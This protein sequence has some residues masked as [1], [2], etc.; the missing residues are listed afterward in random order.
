MIGMA[1]RDQDAVERRR[2]L[3]RR[4]AFRIRLEPRI[5]QQ[6]LPARRTEMEAAVAQPGDC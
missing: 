2:L 1:V 3:P 6:P 4:R 5:D